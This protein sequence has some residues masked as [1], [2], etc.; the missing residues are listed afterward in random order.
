[1]TKK[2]GNGI[3]LKVA[4][5]SDL[6]F[7][8]KPRSD[9]SPSWLQLDGSQIKNNANPWASL[10]ELVES[11]CITADVL[12][13]PGDITTYS[14]KAPLEF[15][16]K[17]LN[18]LRAKLSA[19]I[20]AV[21]T[22]NHDVHSRGANVGS[23]AIR[24][25]NNPSDLFG[26]LKSLDPIYP[27]VFCP[28]LDRSNEARQNRTNYFGNDFVRVETDSLRLIVLN[29]CSI[30]TTTENDF[31]RGFVSEAALKELADQLSHC[32][33]RKINILLC[34]H[35]PMQHEDHRLGS[36]DFML[37]GQLL[38]DLLSQ[39]GD[40]II[41]HGHKHHAK[42]S[43]AQGASS[44]SPVV[45]AA[46]SFSAQLTQS[47]SINSRNQFYVVDI[48]LNGKVGPPLGVIRAW[49]WHNGYPWKENLNDTAGLPTGC[50]FGQREH[51]DKLSEKIAEH[52][53]DKIKDWDDLK[54]ELQSINHLIPGDLKQVEKCL[55]ETFNVF[56]ERDAGVIKRVGKR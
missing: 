38:T 50:G 12:L 29:S 20:L 1:M 39:H 3:N 30:H 54:V 35:H 36:Y 49:N 43:Y 56:F 15:A 47:L 14:E 22:G 24:D 7:F 52:I 18:D 37:H 8:S 4:V 48:S 55:K 26:V 23:N 5:L 44:N 10:Q 2:D 42:L 32:C 11:Q 33:E 19:K 45:F 46:A 40:W 34:H 41:F 27:V 17:C 31:E 25:L 16:W 28:S 9:Q 53:G 21:A 6:H 51:P 13:C